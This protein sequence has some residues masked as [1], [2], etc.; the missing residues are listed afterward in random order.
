MVLSAVINDDIDVCVIDFGGSS[1]SQHCKLTGYVSLQVT[2][3]LTAGVCWAILSTAVLDSS[4]LNQ[5]DF[6]IVVS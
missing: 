1:Q 6:A 2:L 4:S 5:E 3:V